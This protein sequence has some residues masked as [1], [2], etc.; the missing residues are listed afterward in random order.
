MDDD[1]L[2]R[3]RRRLVSL[4]AGRH[5]EPAL[6][7]ALGR[8]REQLEALAQTAAELEGTM[9]ERLGSALQEALHSEVVPVARNLAEVRGLS[10]Q[11]IRRL[12]RLEQ[13]LEVERRARVEDLALLVELIASGWRGVDRRLDRIERALDRMEREREPA[14][15]ELLRL[16]ERRGGEHAGA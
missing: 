2:E 7:A 3:A 10:A 13:L 16:D 14:P 1:V 9:P 11:G 6:E 12:E 15:A 5:D 8:T 4:Q